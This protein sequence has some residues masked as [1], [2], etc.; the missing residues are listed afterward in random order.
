MVDYYKGYRVLGDDLK[1][2]DIVIFNLATLKTV[3]DSSTIDTKMVIGFTHE[4]VRAQFS[5]VATAFA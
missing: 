2:L 3:S 5:V 1:S 4:F